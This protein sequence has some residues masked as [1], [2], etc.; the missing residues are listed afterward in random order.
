MYSLKFIKN[1]IS[2]NKKYLLRSTLRRFLR[3][4]TKITFHLSHK[5][6]H[7]TTASSCKSTDSTRVLHTVTSIHR[8]L[9]FK[10]TIDI[11][12][13][14][15]LFVQESLVDYFIFLTNTSF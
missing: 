10:Q 15:E 12:C 14:S 4:C 1:E 3:L 5:C 8:N 2:L 13:I 11:I 6:N 9:L 7:S